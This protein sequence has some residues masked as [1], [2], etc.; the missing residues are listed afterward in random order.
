[1]SRKDILWLGGSKE[2]AP[3]SVASLL[4][5]IQFVDLSSA[6]YKLPRN[7]PA[8]VIID[9]VT[10]PRDISSLFDQHVEKLVGADTVVYAAAI[11]DSKQIVEIINQRPIDFLVDD[12][13][14]LPRLL[15]NLLSQHSLKKSRSEIESK[16][17]RMR[18]LIRFVK[19]LS[20]VLTLSDLLRLLRV[21]TKNFLHVK[22]PILV[23]L[24][25]VQ[26]PQ[27]HYFQGN[28]VLQKK[29]DA[30]G[31]QAKKIRVNNLQDSQY[32]ADLFGRPFAK[33]IA[34][35]LSQAVLFF[36]HSFQED[37]L[38][39]FLMFIE[40]RLQPIAIAVDRLFLESDLK[41]ASLEWER[42][43]D[44]IQ[45][46]VAIFDL[47]GNM[48]RANHAYAE[49]DPQTRSEKVFE[50]FSYPIAL[51]RG[52]QPTN[53]VNHYVDV[54]LSHKLQKQMI[55]NEK[56]AAI[57]HLAGHIAHELNN[58]LTGVRS[59][60]QVLIPQTLKGTNINKDLVEV[61]RAAERCQLII[62]NLL[63][64]SSGSVSRKT[65]SLNEI[66]NRTLPLLKTAMSPFRQ[67]L[68]LS[69]A[70]VTVDVEPQLMQQVF[71]NLVKNACQAMDENGT[72]TI[73]TRVSSN[74][75]NAELV[76][77]D[78]GSGMTPDILEHIFDFFFTT[79]SQGQGTGL[80]LSMSK[81]I[82]D[83]FGGEISVDSQVGVGSRFSVRL[84][85]VKAA[86]P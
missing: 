7:S 47:E 4:K 77:S 2:T 35:P 68:H 43:F 74:G 14:E 20:M 9:G 70:E 62:K 39:D 41:E 78:T 81:S 13:K 55:Q 82:V 76:V 71:F 42:T 33:L 37:R 69:E 44:G 38:K 51:N 58:P 46:P 59:L 3:D 57:G 27:I 31:S 22:D 53:I 52:E 66:V 40:E 6:N 5:Q 67:E 83:Q 34:V 28:Q 1:M 18:G 61:E 45:D 21:E 8:I 63:E 29:C 79:K 73:E 49:L 25:P 36:E 11:N 10:E 75:E 85:R 64:F 12:T 16:V 80:G 60:A 30:M 15:Q 23:S 65:I 32:L 26:A 72:L 19:D 24:S 56:M 86:H 17:A 54:T 50:T 84:P 48:L